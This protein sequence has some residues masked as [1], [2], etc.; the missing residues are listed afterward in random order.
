MI[1]GNYE[2]IDHMSA[3]RIRN[4]NTTKDMKPWAYS[5]GYTSKWE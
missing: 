2:L 4:I 1:T 5:L 3:M